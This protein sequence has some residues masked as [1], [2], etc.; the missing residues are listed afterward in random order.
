MDKVRGLEI[1][2]NLSFGGTQQIVQTAQKREF[3][4]LVVKRFPVFVNQ[5]C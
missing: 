2:D 3:E 5:S 4:F 1:V